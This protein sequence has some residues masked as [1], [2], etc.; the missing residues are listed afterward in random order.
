[1]PVTLQVKVTPRASCN[2]V[3]GWLDEQ[4][5]ELSL[6]VTAPAEGG[7]ANE[8]VIK[9]LAK[10]LSIP[11]SAIKIQRGA[12]SRHKLI[13]LEISPEV[14]TAWLDTVCHSPV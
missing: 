11:K 6:K 9:L 14:L 3:I 8:A 12:T 1:M 2:A 4:H 13:S 5:E 7:K 10:E